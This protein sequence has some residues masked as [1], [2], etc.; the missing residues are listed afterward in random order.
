MGLGIGCMHYIGMGAIRGCGLDYDPLL[1]AASVAIAIGASMA[2]LWFAF[3]KR[4]IWTTLAGG[5]VQGLAIAA[6]HYTAMDATYF[7]P[8]PTPGD[9]TTPLFS[10]NLLAVVIASA[11][12]VVCVGNLALL[13]LMSMQ[14]RRSI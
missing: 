8:T 3:Y 13:G 5:V 10:Q 4:T 7:V 9:L 12:V 11:I 6:M 1:V 14:Q 2:A